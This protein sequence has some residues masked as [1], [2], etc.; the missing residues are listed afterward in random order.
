MKLGQGA[1][2]VYH[3]R[4]AALFTALFLTTGCEINIF[5][6]YKEHQSNPLFSLHSVL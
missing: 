6:S 4:F 3:D 2:K 5:L 1:L